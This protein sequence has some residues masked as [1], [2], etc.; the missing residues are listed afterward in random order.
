MKKILITGM[1]ASGKTTLG[2]ELLKR[3]YF[4]ID[5]DKSDTCSWQNRETKKPAEYFPG[6]GSKF[7]ADNE[8]F[9][10]FSKVED[11][12]NSSAKEGPVFIVGITTNIFSLLNNF[13]KI[14]LLKINQDVL[15]H[16]LAHRNTNSFGKDEKD[17]EWIISSLNPFQQ[18]MESAGAIP[19]D[20][21]KPVI[22]LA[23]KVTAEIA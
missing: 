17:R 10:D 13:D 12:I 22:G 6:C 18:K 3:G 19:L 23:D 2:S 16:R 5:L 11:I 14:Y 20:G 8:W 21:T 15:K 4:V 9:C 1:S 7:F